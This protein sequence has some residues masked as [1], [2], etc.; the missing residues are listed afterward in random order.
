MLGGAFRM[1]RSGQI[2]YFSFG[3]FYGFRIGSV[4]LVQ[5]T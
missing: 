3:F 4:R 2:R 5:I 1:E